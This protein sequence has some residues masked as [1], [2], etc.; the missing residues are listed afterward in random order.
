MTLLV[1]T[2]PSM[3]AIAGCRCSRKPRGSD[4]D[5]FR[6]LAYPGGEIGAASYRMKIQIAFDGFGTA[7]LSRARARF[8]S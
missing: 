4:V 3:P 8:K 7:G 6:H 2:D 5:P 1:R